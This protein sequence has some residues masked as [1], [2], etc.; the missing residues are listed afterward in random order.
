M[1]KHTRHIVKYKEPGTQNPPSPDES[2]GVDGAECGRSWA[3]DHVQ[4]WSVLPVIRVL[5]R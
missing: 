3:H 2:E 1:I 4:G 5:G